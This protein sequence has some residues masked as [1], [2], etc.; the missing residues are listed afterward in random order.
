[1]VLF[2]GRGWQARDADAVATHFE[3]SRLAVFAQEGGVHRLAVFGTQVKH[4][5]HFDA[6]LDGE[7]ALAVG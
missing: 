6:T 5:A 3:V 7:Q 2:D 1:M 4:M